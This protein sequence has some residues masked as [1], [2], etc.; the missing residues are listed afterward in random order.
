MDL[1]IRDKVAIVS[2]A[3]EG[4]GYASAVA[5]AQEG[6]RLVIGARRQ[7]VL[8]AA[9]E[10]LRRHTG[11]EVLPVSCDV[12]KLDDIHRLI[13]ETASR[14]D[15]RIDILVNNAGGPPFGHALDLDD[16]QWQHGFELTFR[17]VVVCCRRVIPYMRKRKWGRIVTI[18]STSAREPI[19]GLTISNAMRPAII[20]FTKTLSRE[21]AG[22][23]ILVNNVCPGSFLTQRHR[24][25]LPRWARELGCTADE[26]LRQREAEVPLGRFGEPDE[27][28]RVVAF[29]ASDA[30][31]YVTGASLQ[32][33]GGLCRGL[34]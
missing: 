27:L 32:V 30:A 31:S 6:A 20:G 12:T 25:L 17:S 11:A 26:L 10:T 34:L 7:D 23:N 19:D 28:G 29:L 33:D 16:E 15:G 18:T 1:G 14:F 3:S 8:D 4:L 5:L 9:A 13:R 22:D 21:V 24:D 2:G